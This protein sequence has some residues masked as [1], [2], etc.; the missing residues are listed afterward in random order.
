[1]ELYWHHYKYYPYERELALR[2]IN[3]LLMPSLI[4]NV[5]HGIRIESS[6]NIHAAERLAYFAEA[7]DG[8][9]SIHSLQ[10]KLEGANGNGSNRQSTR[11]SVHGL[12]EYK[13]KF[14]P[15]I[16]RAILNIL[17][18]SEGSR[19]L[20]PFCGSGTS[21]VE[22]A[23]MGIKATGTDISPLAVFIA[24]AKLNALC[25]PAVRLR[26]ELRIVIKLYKAL[27]RTGLKQKKDERLQYLE[28][29]FEPK[30][31]TDIERL[32]NA[33]SQG[34]PDCTQV[35]LTIASNLLREYSLQDPQDL[36]IRRRKSPLPETPIIEAFKQATEVFLSRLD[37]AQITLKDRSKTGKAL[38]IDSCRIRLGHNGMD[39]AKFDCAMTSPPYATALPYIDTQR[40]SLVW[41]GLI[42]A[43]QILPL[44]S[45]LI[46]SR[47][48]RG[49]GKKFLFEDLR[50][51]RAGLPA[52]QAAYCHMLQNSLSEN[53]GFRRQAVPIL[54]Y[55]YFAGMAEAF[56]S[57]HRCMKKGAPY[58]LII[59]S[60]HT[61]LG[62]KRFDIDT[63]M[64]LA[65]LA[66]SY[67]WTHVETLPLQTYHRYGYHMN[68]AVNSEALII[69]RS[70]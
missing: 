61:V 48:I 41:L 65:H 14:N 60:N 19:V 27:S 32:R 54:L 51:N 3:S 31:L 53:D 38:L 57:V 15:Q 5:K 26:D 67:G 35:M 17:G 39:R 68:N 64:L 24:N 66:E 45:Q 47:E 10:A 52:K 9:K 55:R 43:S 4:V 40:L 56:S 62:G 8:D 44:E 20:D 33:L 59:G 2:E 46:G 7:K 42:P 22:C 12:H 21:L 6:H 36:R 25:L 11:Y 34:D 16:G 69:L 13:G 49:S 28:T 29:W 63:A 50:I 58:A 18:V 30:I 37:D 1:M 70:I 23:H